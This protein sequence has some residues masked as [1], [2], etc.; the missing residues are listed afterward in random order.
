MST[1]HAQEF[2]AL[3]SR[4]KTIL[5]AL[6]NNRD[7]FQQSVQ[8]QTDKVRKMLDQ[9]DAV[10]GE[11]HA[12][13]RTEIV[14]TVYVADA[15]NREEHAEMRI[16]VVENVTAADASNREQHEATRQQVK[17]LE[18]ALTVLKGEIRKRDEELKEF[19]SAFTQT[20]SPAKRRKL[21]E[22]SNA[23]SAA[24]LALETV[25]RRLEVSSSLEV[26][27]NGS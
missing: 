25:Y 12:K 20:H 2:G 7:V 1:Q 13:T 17:Q 23:V 8:A 15:H 10:I 24:L 4:N 11:E 19:L 16:V 14:Q 6:I 22:R 5:D 3:S 27:Y 18:H 9:T 21:Q 26:V